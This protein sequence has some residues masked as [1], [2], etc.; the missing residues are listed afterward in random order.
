MSY[1]GSTRLIRQEL[2]L[3]QMNTG[4]SK[5]E[6]EACTD[7]LFHNGMMSKRQM[8]KVFGRWC[9]GYVGRTKDQF[10]EVVTL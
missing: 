7:I 2:I 9:K 10:V 5:I 1:T 3:S 6:V 8:V 4:V